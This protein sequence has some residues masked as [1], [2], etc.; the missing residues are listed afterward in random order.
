MFSRA[1][2][3]KLIFVKCNFVSRAHGTFYKHAKLEIYKRMN[4]E[5]YAASFHIQRKFLCLSC[6]TLCC[7]WHVVR[8]N[9]GLAACCSAI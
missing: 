4:L 9:D 5:T 3:I 6:K 8:I 2:R 7:R 1:F